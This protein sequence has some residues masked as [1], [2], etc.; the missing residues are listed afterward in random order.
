[1]R[2]GSILSSG[3]GHGETRQWSRSTYTL[4]TG[5]H[6]TAGRDGQGMDRPRM[7]TFNSVGAEEKDGQ[8]M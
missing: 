5:T 3:F 2:S 1:M 8:T 4:T 7:T 6:R